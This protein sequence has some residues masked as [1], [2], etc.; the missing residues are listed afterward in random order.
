MNL[1]HNFITC[2]GVSPS[3]TP[4]LISD[5]CCF[6]IILTF[7]REGADPITNGQ[8][9]WLHRIRAE[10][11]I[12]MSRG[13]G[14]MG[15][16]PAARLTTNLWLFP[17]IPR[18]DSDLV[19]FRVTKSLS[20]SAY[21]HPLGDRSESARYE[22]SI[23]DWPDCAVVSERF[24]WRVTASAY[25]C[26]INV[27]EPIVNVHQEENDPRLCQQSALVNEN[28]DGMRAYLK[29]PCNFLFPL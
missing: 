17:S 10:V 19:Y 13:F 29:I 5:I 8:A 2:S 14:D 7:N 25:S 16:L 23:N 12:C 21:V 3:Q 20:F 22:C 11:Q 15:V 4:G 1:A 18:S 24:R 28:A 9:V 26:E 6:S 27:P